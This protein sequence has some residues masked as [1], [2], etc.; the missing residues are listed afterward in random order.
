M[1]QRGA[2]KAIG[3][4]LAAGGAGGAGQAATCSGCQHGSNSG[5]AAACC[6]QAGHCAGAWCAQ[7]GHGAVAMVARVPDIG[8]TQTASSG[9]RGDGEGEATVPQIETDLLP[10]VLLLLL[11]K[12]GT[13]MEAPPECWRTGPGGAAAACA[14]A[15]RRRAPPGGVAVASGEGNRREPGALTGGLLQA[16]RTPRRTLPLRG[17]SHR[18]EAIR[19]TGLAAGGRRGG[20]GG[21]ISAGVAGRLPVARLPGAT[22]V[23]RGTRTGGAGASVGW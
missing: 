9:C 15:S 5:T 11:A 12:T 13:W 14:S 2:A 1:G 6:A 17:L 19:S 3:S 10:G 18:S 23:G 21:R 7:E 20:A 4:G 16:L 8:D 22:H